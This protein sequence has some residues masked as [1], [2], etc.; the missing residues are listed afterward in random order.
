M[1]KTGARANSRRPEQGCHPGSRRP[2]PVGILDD[3]QY[4]FCIESADFVWYLVQCPV[5]KDCPGNVGLESE[6]KHGVERGCRWSRLDDLVSMYFVADADEWCLGW[7]TKAS[8]TPAERR[9]SAG[10]HS[11]KTLFRMVYIDGCHCISLARQLG[12]YPSS[13]PHHSSTSCYNAQAF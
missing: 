2:L 11:G 1:K 9:K 7:I 13:Y 3:E 4:A 8:P 12:Y 6:G 10:G 5:T